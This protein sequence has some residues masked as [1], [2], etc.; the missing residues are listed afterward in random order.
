MKKKQYGVACSP[1]RLELFSFGKQEITID[2]SALYAE[3]FD[4]SVQNIQYRKE[5]EENK[6]VEEAVITF[7]A[8]LTIIPDFPVTEGANA[9]TFLRNWSANNAKSNL[10]LLASKV[11]CYLSRRREQPAGLDVNGLCSLYASVER[12]YLKDQNANITQEMHE[13][14]KRLLNVQTE[15][16]RYLNGH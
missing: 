1:E 11:Q 6:K 2:V 16:V 12:M 4:L 3:L 8:K 14:Y 13:E 10:D 15:I 9:S 7:Q 5:Q